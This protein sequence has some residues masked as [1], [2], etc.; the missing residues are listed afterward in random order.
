MLNQALLVNKNEAVPSCV[1]YYKA[2]MRKELLTLNGFIVGSAL[3]RIGGE[4]TVR[5][6]TSDIYI[7]AVELGIEKTHPNIVDRCAY[8]DAII[9]SIADQIGTA[10]LRSGS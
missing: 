5:D 2:D 3:G 4:P 1:D 6:K 8:I 10:S 9:C 7:S